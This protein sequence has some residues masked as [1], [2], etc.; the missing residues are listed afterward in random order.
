MKH[1]E[2]EVKILDINKQGFINKIKKLW[3]VLKIETKQYNLWK[4]Y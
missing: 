4:I 1:M 3:V 2:L